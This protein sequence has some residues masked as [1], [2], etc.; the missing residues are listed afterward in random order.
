MI[1]RV[2]EIDVFW[3]SVRVVICDWW[4]V[5]ECISS[6]FKDMNIETHISLLLTQFSVE[7][8]VPTY[9]WSSDEM[10]W[11]INLLI[12][13]SSVSNFIINLWF[14]T[15]GFS[16]IISESVC[17]YSKNIFNILFAKICHPVLSRATLIQV[18]SWQ[19]IWVWF[20]LPIPVRLPTTVCSL[21]SSCKAAKRP[22]HEKN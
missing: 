17:L 7:L 19:W 18:I 10:N 5:P 13:S 8:F 9:P 12:T 14:N 21:P 3:K 4:R 15:Y 6:L 16:W 2:V 1:Y 20:F 11:V 22:R